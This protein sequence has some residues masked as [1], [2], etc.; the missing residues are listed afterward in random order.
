[1][2]EVA[3][4]F[5]YGLNASAK[6]FDGVHKYI[7]ITDIDDELRHFD[8]SNLTSPDIDFEDA[9]SYLLQRG[10][11]LFARTGASVG[12]SY[13]HE[14]DEE[15][16]YFAG[17]LIRA[18]FAE[19]CNPDF[20]FQNTLTDKYNI[21][22]KVMSQR[23]GQ[24]G[25]N[26][27]EYASY[28]LGMPVFEE[29][30]KLGSFFRTLDDIIALHKRKLDGLRKLKV[31]YLQQMFP[32]AGERVPRVRFA[33]F[34]GDWEE[35]RFDEIV[36]RVSIQSNA[37]NVPK[38]EF[39]DIVS[40]EGMLNKDVA[41]K[42]DSRKGI[43]FEPKDILYGKLR[44]YLRNWL[45]AD[46][47]GVALGDFWVLRA[48]DT[49]PNFNYALIQTDKYQE[50]ANLSTGTKMPRSDW[51]IVSETDFLLPNETTEQSLIGN[52][53]HYLDMHLSTQQAKLTKLKQLKQAYLQK[54]FV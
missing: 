48:T 33:G 4:H 13:I 20:I 26:A 25:V 43:A 40:G 2:G 12:K 29:Q 37:N 34:T 44:P 47:S 53:F 11:I 1:M 35:R 49:V 18:R 17:F 31:G 5:E 46:F 39:E 52:F 15:V 7:R 36:N 38:V 51:K 16:V 45:F 30:Q 8:E 27:Q 10:D 24:P 54:M 32:Q 41:S 23:S 42:F 14:S 22:I 50:V 21:F 6:D 28:S 19:E 9:D 3:K